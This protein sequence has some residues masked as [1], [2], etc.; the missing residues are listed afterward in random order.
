MVSVL[1]PQ[2]HIVKGDVVAGDVLVTLDSDD[3]S[4]VSDVFAVPVLRRFCQRCGWVS[5]T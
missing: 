1:G 3:R 5:M 4:A 2:I